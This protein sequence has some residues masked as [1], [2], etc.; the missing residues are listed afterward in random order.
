MRDGRFIVDLATVLV[1]FQNLP[2]PVVNFKN[3]YFTIANNIS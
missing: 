2:V 1:P 3:N